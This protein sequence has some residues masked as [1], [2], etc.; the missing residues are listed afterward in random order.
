[1]RPEDAM[2]DLEKAISE[3]KAR[4]RVHEILEDGLAADLETQLRDSIDAVKKEGASD[5]DAFAKAE[6]RLGPLEAI[7]DEYRKNRLAALDRRR[8]FRAS[9][10]F[11]SLAGNYLKTAWRKARR[12]KA[13]AAINLAGLAVGLACGILT[14]LYVRHELSYDRYH[15]RKD[16]IVRL[17][18]GVRGGAYQA[19][20][21]V[22]GPWGLTALKEIPEIERAVRFV[23]MNEILVGRGEVR[24]YERGG[25]YADASVFEVFSFPLLRGDPA[26]ALAHPGTVVI[27]E[28]FARKFFGGADALGASLTFDSKTDYLITGVMRDV[29]AESHFRFDFLVSMETYA[30]P[31]REDWRWNQ[32]YTYLLLREGASP[33][34]VAAKFPALLGR[35]MAAAD[36]AGYAT[37]FQKLTDIHLRSHL[38]REI[39]PNSDIAN[40]IIFS[41][42]AFLILAI[43]GI[44]FMNLTTARALARA[45]EVGVRKAVGASRS[46]LAR[47]F[48]GESLL[49]SAAAFAVALGLAALLL[50]VFRPLAGRSLALFGPSQTGFLAAMAGLSLA[51]G[52][53]AGAYPAFVLSSFRPSEALRGRARG[54]RGDLMRKGLVV[55]QFAASAF[56]LVATG[57]VSDQLRFVQGRRL[58]FDIGHLIVVPIRDD[59]M[60]AGFEAAKRELMSVPGVVSASASGNLPGGSDWG[61]P[62]EAEGIAP[63]RLPPMRQLLV[64]EDFVATYRFELAAG[65][66][67]ALDHPT[68]ATAAVMINEEAARQLAWADPLGR[69]MAVPVL[70]HGPSPVIGVIKDFHFRS[71]HE[72]I[73]PIMLLTATPEMMTVISLRIRADGAP[74]TL[75]G[76]ERKWRELDP[77]HPFTYSFLDEGFARLYDRERRTGTLLLSVAGLAVFVA[78]LGLFGLAAYAARKRTKEI[79]I[80]KTVGASTRSIVALLS[81]DFTRLVAIGYLVAVPAVVWLMSRWLQGFAYRRAIGIGPFA[82]AGIAVLAAGWLAVGFQSVRAAR[83]NPTDALRY[84]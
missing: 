39:E 61:V 1:M 26:T 68:D 14:T 44:N 66:S 51:V 77:A 4:L 57:I 75:A 24:S 47:Q 81:G 20:A 16:R 73:G 71:L 5:E 59:K 40:V 72:K 64:D 11:P 56:L 37:S 18:T 2:F 45:K 23:L 69:T 22:P 49:M 62:Y 9:R 31:M 38:F 63:D 10:F 43:A 46:Q 36:A 29:P 83:A 55:F 19:I 82:A 21:K 78:C 32:F 60:R 65:R 42:V 6:A 76:L 3:W 33:G 80:R 70:K 74:A 58:G 34:A 15:A 52:I 13:Y 67:F 41:A 7:A 84:E 28:S 48:L 12:E 53:A 50:P 27:T 25:L 17:V 8:P 30:N 79:G 54:L 35:H